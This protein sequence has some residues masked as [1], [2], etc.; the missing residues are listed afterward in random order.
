M[1]YLSCVDFLEAFFSDGL[2]GCGLVAPKK[3]LFPADSG[4]PLIP[5]LQASS[6]Q[7]LAEQNLAEQ[8]R[9]DQIRREIVAALQKVRSL[10]DVRWLRTQQTPVARMIADKQSGLAPGV[11]LPTSEILESYLI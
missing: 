8:S 4:D 7:N 10:A 1:S 5:S 3:G 9:V 6:E 2:C 11:F